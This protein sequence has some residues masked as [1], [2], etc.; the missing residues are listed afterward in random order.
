MKRILTILVSWVFVFFSARFN[1][2]KI[3]W[4]QINS[5]NIID[6]IIKQS[7]ITESISSLQIGNYNNAELFLNN[8]TAILL[9]QIG[10][11]NKVYFNNSF[12]ETSAKAS[13]TTQGYNNIIDITGSNSISEKLKLNVKGDNMTIF[14][15]NY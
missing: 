12:T 15:R 3:S 4:G 13:I 1:A 10:D 5:N 2:Q 11:F 6:V 9:Q 7:V 8:R 14:I